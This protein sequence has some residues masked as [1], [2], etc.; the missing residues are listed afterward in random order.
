MGY[1]GGKNAF[2]AFFEL[3]LWISKILFLQRNVEMCSAFF[4][5]IIHIGTERKT[6][7]LRKLFC[8]AFEYKLNKK[9]LKKVIKCC[10]CVFCVIKY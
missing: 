2:A 7:C 1:K 8:V 9:R 10:K 4:I 5:K 3:L 6:K